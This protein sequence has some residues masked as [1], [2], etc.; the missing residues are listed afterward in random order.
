MKAAIEGSHRPIKFLNQTVLLWFVYVMFFCANEIQLFS[1]QPGSR[2]ADGFA[3]G[4][5]HRFGLSYL[6]LLSG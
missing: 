4:C 5:Q 2:N 1:V 6:N 3:V